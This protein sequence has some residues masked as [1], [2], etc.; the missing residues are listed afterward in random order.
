MVFFLN[1][2]LNRFGIRFIKEVQQRTAEVMRVDI[3]ISQL[4]CD[5]IEEQVT[6][7]VVQVHCQILQNIHVC[8]VDD[9][10]H[11]WILAFGAEI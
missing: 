1:I 7:F 5:R 4:I 10:R 6:A 11:R 3:R 2:H 9:I 8:V